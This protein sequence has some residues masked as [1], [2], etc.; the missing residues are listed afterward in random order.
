MTTKIIRFLGLFIV[1]FLCYTFSFFFHLF[2]MS[3]LR[4]RTIFSHLIEFHR[5]RVIGLRGKTCDL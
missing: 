2:Q 4:R 3:L 5:R 1:K